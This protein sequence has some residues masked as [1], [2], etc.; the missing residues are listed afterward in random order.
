VVLRF[1]EQEDF[2]AYV[3]HFHPD[4][5]FAGVGGMF[6]NNGYPHI[7]YGQAWTDHPEAPVL[8][9]EL[10]HNLVAHLPLPLWLNEALAMAFEAEIGG[11]YI[12]PLTREDAARHR[13]YWTAGTIQEFWRG[14][15]FSD[16]E[17]QELAYSLA[18]VLLHLIHTEIRPAKGEFRRFVLAANWE[19]AGATAA[20]EHLGIQL[21]DIVAAFLG[22][23]DWAPRPERWSS[24][25]SKGG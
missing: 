21:E 7:V 13:D 11:S 1:T 5:E 16:V 15:S 9:H 24:R 20:A 6:L 22:A 3:S 2:Y 10:A 17:G 19:D 14:D 12:P 18:R 25:E 4:G 23:G 8:V